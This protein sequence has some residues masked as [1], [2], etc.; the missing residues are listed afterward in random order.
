[1]ILNHF[2]VQRNH[3]EMVKADIVGPMLQ[4]GYNCLASRLT[5]QN[6]ISEGCIIAV[7]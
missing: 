6:L 1:M 5:S 4:D 2:Q 7:E 3:V